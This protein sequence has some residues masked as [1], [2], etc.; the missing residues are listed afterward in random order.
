MTLLRIT[1][2]RRLD[3]WQL[4]VLIVLGIAFIVLGSGCA[5]TGNITLSEPPPVRY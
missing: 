4:V 5:T 2:L 3:R 1:P